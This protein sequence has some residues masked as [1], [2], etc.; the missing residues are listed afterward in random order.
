MLKHMK[1][2]GLCKR[3]LNQILLEVQAIYSRPIDK[4]AVNELQNLQ[5]GKLEFIHLFKRLYRE[6]DFSDPAKAE[7]QEK[8]LL[9]EHDSVTDPVKRTIARIHCKGKTTRESLNLHNTSFS[10][11]PSENIANLPKINI[12]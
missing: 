12:P 7:K 4:N 2:S 5:E 11:Y 10:Q 8:E 9:A 1:L 6:I 3:N